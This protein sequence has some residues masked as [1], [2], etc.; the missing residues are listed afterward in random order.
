MATIQLKLELNEVNK[1]L[2]AL[3]TMPFVEVYELVAKIQEQAQEQ[4]DDQPG[5]SVGAGEDPS[6]E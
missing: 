1:I 5:P 2:S 4:L 3:G 6:N